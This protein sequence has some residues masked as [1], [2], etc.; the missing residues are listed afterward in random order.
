MTE[1]NIPSLDSVTAEFITNLFQEVMTGIHA[2][3]EQRLQAVEKS[4]ESIEKQIASL[5]INKIF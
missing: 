5:L 2:Q 4:I 3:V 1:E